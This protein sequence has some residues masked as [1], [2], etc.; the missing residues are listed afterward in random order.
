MGLFSSLFGGG[1]KTTVTQAA[2]NN[3]NVTVNNTIDMEA[4]AD[5]ITA[6]GLFTATA[7]DNVGKQTK[8]VLTGLLAQVDANQKTQI[9]A[10]IA[11]V[12]QRVKQNQILNSGLSVV[13]I[14]ALI[15]G[16]YW[17]WRRL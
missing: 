1:S 13:K 15:G 7:V 8:D 6:V 11:D 5:A 2:T 14:G 16:A 9:V 12:Q 17:I 4:L 10:M 3:T